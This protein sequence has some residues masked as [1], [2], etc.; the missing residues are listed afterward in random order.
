M[1]TQK[2]P[3]NWGEKYH[4]GI[5]EH[6]GCSCPY[7]G[8]GAVSYGDLINGSKTWCDSMIGFSRE[9]AKGSVRT[10][11][12]HK[13]EEVIGS[14]IL[15]CSNCFEKYFIHITREGVDMAKNKCP[16]WPKDK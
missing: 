10:G 4:T 12:H 8:N 3:A 16:L 2:I 6:H 1:S 13:Q 14:A 5:P 15:E 7:C 9:I 11:A